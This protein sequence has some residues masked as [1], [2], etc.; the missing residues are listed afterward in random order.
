MEARIGVAPRIRSGKPTV[1]GTRILVTNISAVL[2]CASQVIDEEE[3]VPRV[4]SAW[5]GQP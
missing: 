2:S 3:V 5:G 1:G 4:R